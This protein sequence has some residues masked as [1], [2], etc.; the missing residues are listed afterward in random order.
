MVKAHIHLLQ[1]RCIFWANLQPKVD[2][3]F[4]PV[5]YHCQDKR[6]QTSQNHYQLYYKEKPMSER[7]YAPVHISQDILDRFKKLPVATIWNHVMKDAGVPLPF[8]EGA[9]P[10][11]I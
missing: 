3:I 7:S 5:Y 1:K 2:N 8:M 6:C 4:T 9:R 10:F 11:T